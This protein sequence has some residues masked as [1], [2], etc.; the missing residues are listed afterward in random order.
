S[1]DVP[2]F[3]RW[4]S[5]IGSDRDGNPNVTAALTRHALDRHRATALA[6]QLEE[7]HELR[8]ELSISDRLTAAPAAL[9]RRLEEMD[10]DPD[11]AR[12]YRHEPYRRLIAA[13]EHRLEVLLGT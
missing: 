3:L 10:E 13:I 7:L 6:M 8:E 4:R 12:A 9:G 1:P 2:V 5:R 11:D